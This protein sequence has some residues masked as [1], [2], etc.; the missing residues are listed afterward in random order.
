MKKKI[1]EGIE[2][3]TL[4]NLSRKKEA[5]YIGRTSIK[6]VADEMHFFLEVY[7]NE[8]AAKGVPL[9]RIVVN[10]KDFGAFWPED[11]RWSRA[12]ITSNGYYEGLIWE[13]KGSREYEKRRKENIL[14]SPEDLKRLKRFFQEINV[15]NDEDW[16]KYISEK[17]SRIC[18]E[19]RDARSRRAFEK[20]KAAL[21]DRAE[22]TP[23]LDE[24]RLL[25]YAER[26][27]FMEE[28]YLYYKKKGRRAKVCCS[29]CGG[30]SSGAFKPGISYESN[31]ER[32]I[33]EPREN[34]RGTCPVC[35]EPGIYKC[36]GKAKRE[37]KKSKHI[38]LM[39]K[40]KEIGVVIRYVEL[41]KEWKLE[42][43]FGEKGPEIHGAYEKLDC[44]EIARTYIHPGEKTQTDFHKHNEYSGDFWDDCNTYG[45]ANIQIKPAE[46][47]P[48][49]WEKLEGTCLQYSQAK[50]FMREIGNSEVAL[51]EFMERY[52]HIPQ[53]E[54]LVKL[55]MF[56]VVRELV[57]YRY[58]IV[59]NIN[60]KSPDA[61]LEI[62]KDKVKFLIKRKGDIGILEILQIE[63]RMEENWTEEQVVKLAE[64]E[65]KQ[66]NLKLILQFMTIQKLLN[67]IE[68]Y[69]GCEYGT[70]CGYGTGRI[71]HTATTYF[72]YI[73]MRAQLGYD[74]TN[75]V[76]QKPRN[77]EQAHNKMA[78][79]INKE[80]QEK[81][82]KEVAEK[83]PLIRKN[84]RKL[85]GRYLYEDE[86]FIIRP[87]RSA[88]EIVQEGMI[89]H[90]CV[91]GDNYLKKHNEEKSVILML[92]FKDQQ[93]IPYI[94]V[95]ID[96]ERIVQWHGAYNKK[97]DNENMQ[98][99][100]D[101]Y[102]AMLRCKR[103]GMIENPW[104]EVVQPLL[105]P[106]VI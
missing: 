50:E 85:R 11:G 89:L 55:Q 59:A 47:Y 66:E 18:W 5:K 14:Y 22:H 86:H 84:Y 79:E 88:E 80:K 78:E 17:Q 9:V 34:K 68:K 53:I 40:Y 97:P 82:F 33:E 70:E 75:T 96:E 100:L 63:K 48:E 65:A 20:K 91:G 58:G 54:M 37:Y 73:S 41:E 45:M 46:V 101:A 30:V 35:H 71:K 51:H 103:Q 95:E 81:R 69:A 13:K 3:L 2:F 64:I 16:W 38:F 36:Q 29:K 4:P 76:Y 83:F 99:W 61:F 105:M 57:R 102:T 49:A 106:A 7:K 44:R 43:I 67:I 56:G 23:E 12:K 8:K 90:H 21:K 52:M 92:R 60:A 32:N 26:H 74:L 72:D 27:I 77:L 28:H 6:Q 39:D 31:F 94:T 98:R 42:E 25:E 104:Q 87:A 24:Q 93:E 1:I 19:E 15:W 10:K 62:K